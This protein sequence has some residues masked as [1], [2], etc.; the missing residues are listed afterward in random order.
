MDSENYP[1]V[2][3]LRSIQCIIIKRAL[4]CATYELCKMIDVQWFGACVGCRACSSDLIRIC[5]TFLGD[6]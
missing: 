4:V 3:G 1:F 5:G 2:A 6:G